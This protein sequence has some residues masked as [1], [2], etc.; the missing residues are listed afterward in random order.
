VGAIAA[1]ELGAGGVGDVVGAGVGALVADSVDD[2]EVGASVV[3]Y[4]SVEVVDV[5]P[6]A[7][8]DQPKLGEALPVLFSYACGLS[9]ATGP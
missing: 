4:I 5:L 9:V 7:G 1:H 2:G 8:A 6:V 3:A